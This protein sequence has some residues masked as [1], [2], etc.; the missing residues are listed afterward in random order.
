MKK[1]SWE[2]IL[3][4]RLIMALLA[5]FSCFLWGSAFP[6]IKMGYALFQISDNDTYGQILFAGFRFFLAGLLVFL[7]CLIFRYPLKVTK[8]QLSKLFLLG[9]LQTSMQY[10]FFYIGMANISGTTGSILAALATFFSVMLAP[11]FFT[12][13]RL[14]APKIIGVFLGFGGIIVLNYSGIAAT[15]IRFNGEG[16]LIVSSFVSALA[17]IYTKKLTGLNISSFLISAYQLS[18]GGLVLTLAGLI[19]SKGQMIH[20]T[21]P[22]SLLLLYMS[23]ISAAAFSV[24]TILLTY[25]KVAA[26]NIYKFSIPLFGILLSFFFLGERN[27]HI[28]VLIAIVLITAGILLINVEK[29]KKDG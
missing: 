23:F 12:D 25:N 16:F 8:K 15:T 19:G 2:T 22:G 14:T 9:L 20:F 7:S 11:V 13:D 28:N 18:L 4:N 1:K 10:F 17:S 21:L 24:W 27:L 6:S 5:L 26:V 29:K 3:T